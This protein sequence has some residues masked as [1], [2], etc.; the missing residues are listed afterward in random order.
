MFNKYC[1][2]CGAK[3]PDS[4]GNNKYCSRECSM[5]AV[6][7]KAGRAVDMTPSVQLSLPYLYGAMLATA[8]VTALLCRIFGM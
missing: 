1:R 8:I 7:Y 5:R 3:M 6:N 2:Y 4:K